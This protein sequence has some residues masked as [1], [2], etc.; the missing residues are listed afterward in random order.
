MM[1]QVLA[2]YKHLLGAV[3]P[4][5]WAGVLWAFYFFVK[6]SVDKIRDRQCGG[7]LAG[8]KTLS[9][10][11]YWPDSFVPMLRTSFQCAPMLQ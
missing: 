4:G 7:S 9:C 1:D 5:P 3:A 10:H 11:G 6:G 2:T 8:R